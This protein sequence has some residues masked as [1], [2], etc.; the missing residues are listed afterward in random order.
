LSNPITAHRT[1]W[2]GFQKTIC[3]NV[4]RHGKGTG[5]HISQ[6][7]STLVLKVND[8]ILF[9]Y[10]LSQWNFIIKEYRMK[11]LWTKWWI[12]IDKMVAMEISRN[13]GTQI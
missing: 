12:N 5:K 9:F 3:R 6:K 4:S 11:I 13:L 1:R 8:S 7:A 2:T 10:I